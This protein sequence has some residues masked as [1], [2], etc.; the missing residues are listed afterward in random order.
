[1]KK[2]PK[3]FLISRLKKI[4]GVL[5]TQ[6]LLRL[7]GGCLWMAKPA[8]SSIAQS[9]LGDQTHLPEEEGG[10]T[11]EALLFVFP[12]LNTT[13]QGD[14][15]S[16]LD[17]KYSYSGRQRFSVLMETSRIRE[18]MGVSPDDLSL[19]RP[20]LSTV[21]FSCNREEGNNWNSLLHIGYGSI[22]STTSY[23]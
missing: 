12:T 18:R 15:M 19:C 17:V 16:G 11:W 7:V 23:G 22:F 9:L 10:S 20:F 5:N 21:L 14:P 8:R 3:C 13:A 4:H 1:M 6:R 2:D